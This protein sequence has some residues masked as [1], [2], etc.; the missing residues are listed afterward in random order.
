MGGLVHALSRGSLTLFVCA[1]TLACGVLLV[2]GQA[3]ATFIDQTTS[4]PASQDL[5]TYGA[6][7]TGD[8]L[9]DGA[10]R[11][12]ARTSSRMCIMYTDPENV[13]ARDSKEQAIILVNGGNITAVFYLSKA[14]NYIYLGTQEQAAASTNEDG[15]DASAYIAGD[16]AEGYVPHLYYLSVPALNTPMTIA[17]FSGGDHGIEGGMWYTRQVVFGMT[18]AEFQAI[19]SGE[20]ASENEGNEKTPDE[21]ASTSKA[22]AESETTVVAGAVTGDSDSGGN[23]GE[24]AAPSE[25]AAPVTEP[26]VAASSGMRGVRLTPVS[27]PA[28]IDVS[29][30]AETDVPAAEAA[31]GFGLPHAV[32]L[33]FAAAIVLGALMRSLAFKRGF[34]NPRA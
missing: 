21:N 22:A 6:P 1:I 30:P 10:Y 3:H 17:T 5:G 32:A 13:E 23:S 12:T 27:A 4:F 28:A 9:P 11:V 2:P 15:T 25:A 34:G 16:P 26:A 14:Y 31:A 33:A 8:Q 29:L 18:D 7:I 19:V 20:P 24:E